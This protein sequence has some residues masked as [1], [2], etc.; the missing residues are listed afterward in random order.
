MKPDA[1]TDGQIVDAL[2][3]PS[4]LAKRFGLQRNSVCNWKTRGIPRWWRKMVAEH[5][6]R[7]KIAL[8]GDFMTRR[9]G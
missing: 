3:G 6:R 2:G 9:D 4:A 7:V 5:A 8:P 1:M